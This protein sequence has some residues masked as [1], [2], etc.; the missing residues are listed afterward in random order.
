MPKPKRDPA[1][2]QFWWQP[3]DL[4]QRH[5]HCLTPDTTRPTRHPAAQKHQLTQTST[6]SRSPNLHSTKRTHLRWTA[7][8]DYVP[9]VSPTHAQ[10]DEIARLIRDSRQAHGELTGEEHVIRRL[11]NLNMSPP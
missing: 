1:R 8:G 7:K 10:A 9:V 5:P 6:S 2:E 11:V 3:L 4:A